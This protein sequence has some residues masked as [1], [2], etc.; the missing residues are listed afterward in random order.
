VYAVRFFRKKLMTDTTEEW[1]VR[2]EEGEKEDG[3][4]KKRREGIPKEHPTNP[5]VIKCLEKNSK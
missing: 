2:E 5:N 4:K 1:E 3:R